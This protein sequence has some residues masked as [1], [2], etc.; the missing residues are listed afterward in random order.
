MIKFRINVVGI[1]M[2]WAVGSIFGE[3][4]D[5]FS[6]PSLSNTSWIKNTDDITVQ[7]D[8]GTCHITNPDTTFVAFISHSFPEDAKPSTFTISGKV[9]LDSPEMGAGFIYC[10]SLTTI[11]TGYYLT[12]REGNNVVVNTI[13]ASGSGE[14]VFNMHSPFL[15]AG[16]NI[17]T[18]SK[19]DSVSNIFCNGRYL[20]T[21]TDKSFNDGDIALLVAN[22]SGAVFDDIVMTDSFL[23]V[24]L[25]TCFSDDFSDG[26]LIGWG[27]FGSADAS[28]QVENEALHLTTSTGQTIYQQFN[29]SLTGFVMQVT[30][31][32]RS[33]SNAN[34]YG[35]FVSGDGTDQVPIA[36]FG[37]A[38]NRTF[39]TFLAGESYS[40]QSH[41]VIRGAAYISSA[42]DTTFYKD[43]LSIIK[44]DGS[45]DYLFVVNA[46]TV[47]KFTGVNFEITGA[48]IF[49]T[50]SLAIICDDFLL[51]KGTEFVCPVVHNVMPSRRIGGNRIQIS[52]KMIDA[53]LF[54]CSGRLI[55]RSR[56]MRTRGVVPGLYLSREQKKVVYR[57]R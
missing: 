13:D 28:V 2:C 45:D 32:H 52:P 54:D 10:M 14:V 53:Y 20:G 30:I 40:P 6:E 39:G 31:T 22:K 23:P 42:G 12:L 1:L 33:G 3:F 35:L 51:N 36:G 5:D 56:G 57:N 41:P 4:A 7:F 38:G 44:R 46:D 19:K 47:T 48:G 11:A 25:P 50:D 8:N 27:R 9:T 15:T 17:L 16:T 43:T 55:S 34:M 18:V 49:V 37:I 24:V 29:M 21:F 26:N